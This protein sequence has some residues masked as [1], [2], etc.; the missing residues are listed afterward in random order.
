[1]LG[2]Q[3]RVDVGR[4]EEHVE[5]TLRDLWY[6]KEVAT[7]L[8]LTKRLVFPAEDQ[9]AA[10][11]QCVNET[12]PALLFSREE[13]DDSASCGWRLA[14]R[15]PAATPTCSAQPTTSKSRTL[16]GRT[17]HGY[18]RRKTDS[19]PTGSSP[20]SRYHPRRPATPK[21][22]RGA[23]SGVLPRLMLDS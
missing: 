6:Q 12:V 15:C 1:M 18:A 13:T 21:A 14:T 2:L 16:T 8:G 4:W 23:G 7:S 5:L 3:E 11:A 17:P 9:H 20:L 10:I 22:S 19:T